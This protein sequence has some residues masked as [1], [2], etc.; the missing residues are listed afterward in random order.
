MLRAAGLTFIRDGAAVLDGVELTLRAGELC[1]LLGP[2]GG[3]KSTLLRLLAGDYHARLFSRGARLRG[4]LSLDGTAFERLDAAVLARRRA[5]LPQSAVR[6]FRFTALDWVALGRYPHPTSAGDAGMRAA[7]AIARRALERADGAALAERDV[8][9]LSGGEFAR[10]QFAR[11]LAQ[12]WPGSG[13][14][15]D[16]PRYLL[17]DEPTAALDLRHQR[18]LLQTTQ[19]LTREWGIGVLAIVHDV[20]LAARHADRLALLSAGRLIAC[21]P[22]RALLDAALLG[23]CFGT[24]VKV[25]ETAELPLPIVLPA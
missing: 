19:A 22:P 16:A 23:R 8:T 18:Q 1:A 10:V 2:N 6:A 9:T 20:N 21:G 25:V 17:L 13:T 24:A 12:I 5:V 15:F 4:S 3:G 11:A 7:H 14:A